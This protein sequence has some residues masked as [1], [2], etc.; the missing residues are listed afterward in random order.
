MLFTIKPWQRYTGRERE[1]LKLLLYRDLSSTTNTNYTL[2]MYKLKLTENVTKLGG[3]LLAVENN[4]ASYLQ[5]NKNLNDN[6]VAIRTY[7]K[8]T[9]LYVTSI[10]YV[11]YI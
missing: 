5:C 2:D 1:G 7:V 8:Y 6:R 4:N 3:P 9:R 11:T 10:K